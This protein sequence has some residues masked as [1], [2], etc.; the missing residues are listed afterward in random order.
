[1]AQVTLAILPIFIQFDT[2]WFPKTFVVVVEIRSVRCDGIVPLS[3]LEPSGAI[4]VTPCI[5]LVHLLIVFYCL[6]AKLVP[7]CRVTATPQTI[8]HLTQP[9]QAVSHIFLFYFHSKKS[10]LYLAS[11][12][13]H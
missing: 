11:P 8:P 9:Q 4:S 2:N 10:G 5:T 3:Y 1:M 6:V 7:T 12:V 13:I